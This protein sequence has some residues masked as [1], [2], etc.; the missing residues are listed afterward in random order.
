MSLRRKIRR[1]FA[2]LFGRSSYVSLAEY[3]R[4]Q[5]E[6][7]VEGF[8]AVQRVKDELETIKAKLQEEQ[9]AREALETRLR[10][11][12]RNAATARRNQRN[13]Q[14]ALDEAN[15]A[16]REET[17]KRQQ[18]EEQLRALEQERS[19]VHAG[20][21][22]GDNVAPD[23]E[24]TAEDSAN[25]EATEQPLRLETQETVEMAPAP[26]Q[27]PPPEQEQATS[28]DPLE[29]ETRPSAG[30]GR[31]R[32]S[33]TPDGSGSQASNRPQAPPDEL[34]E[35]PTF[36]RDNIHP[37]FR[38]GSRRRLAAEDEVS[39]AEE[40]QR[41]RDNQRADALFHLEC[42]FDSWDWHLVL[43]AEQQDIECNGAVEQQGQLVRWRI[44]SLDEPITVT[45]QKH[46]GIETISVNEQLE[47]PLVFRLSGEFREGRRVRT[48][49]NGT[50]LV[51]HE[52]DEDFGDI[53]PECMQFVD[54][55]LQGCRG[56]LVIAEDENAISPLPL[57]PSGR[58]LQNA[59]TLAGDILYDEESPT[60]F[61]APP[62]LRVLDLR[63]WRR[64]NLIVL[65]EE[66][67]GRQ[68]WRTSFRPQADQLEQR[69]PPSLHQ[70]PH[71]W[72]F[73]RFYGYDATTQHWQLLHSDHFR[74]V[75]QLQALEINRPPLLSHDNRPITVTF[76]HQHDCAITPAV[77][78]D[79]QALSPEHQVE[80]ELK[81]TT[82]PWIPSPASPKLS[83][84][85]QVDGFQTTIT[86]G[87]RR[88]WWAV[89]TEMPSNTRWGTSTASLDR[90]D[91]SPTSETKLWVKFS[92]ERLTER[93][94][95]GFGQM[96]AFAVGADDLI[97]E[98]PLRN[99]TDGVQ[100][101]QGVQRL[102]LKTPDGDKVTAAEV[103]TLVRCTCCRVE[104]SS[105][106]QSI[107][108]IK[109]LLNSGDPE[110]LD[111]FFP[112][113]SYDQIRE[114]QPNSFPFRIFKCSY[115]DTYTQQM[116]PFVVTAQTAMETHVSTVHRGR[117]V[118]FQAINDANRIRE[119]VIHNLPNLRRCRFCDEEFELTEVKTTGRRHLLQAHENDLWEVE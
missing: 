116:N 20:P 65:G 85:I 18:L 16:L 118:A 112:A 21:E 58:S 32:R 99:F 33:T 28:E 22:Q 40:S 76:R 53:D 25:E 56:L 70:R 48:I 73:L 100:Y 92:E 6:A 14:H 108:H 10:T 31:R 44:L 102:R 103:K 5:T 69:L 104:L 59:V 19:L 2:R 114:R 30:A 38:G 23:S 4:V 35:R 110:H 37:I 97:R 51:I 49:S 93:I 84:E 74:F 24:I 36:R 63:E 57:E 98:I 67:P 41:V 81:I 94:E 82:Y 39:E 117:D 50:Y 34:D 72:Y 71:G 15:R 111:Y 42:W 77:Q 60:L 80:N 91:L 52:A 64:V 1:F 68:R 115:C 47:L 106:Q 46:A 62:V 54:V 96:R 83:F 43:V 107:I 119:H 3:R 86:V 29:H 7:F 113:L 66:G 9:A 27:A 13:L 8:L 109:S 95:V 88:A 61:R 105:L 17:E 75:S 78:S 11:A 90:N 89:A 79:D 12:R 101:G 45:R 55:S 26:S 87:A